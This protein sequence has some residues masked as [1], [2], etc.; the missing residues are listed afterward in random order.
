VL[1]IR[2]SAE[3][4]TGRKVN[5]V[6]GPRRAGDPSRLVADTEK[7]LRVLGW[8]AE[9]SDIHTIISDAW[10]WHLAELAAGRGG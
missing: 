2:D 6:L 7:A 5:T 1:E 3:K 10:A 9:C 4:I 8:K